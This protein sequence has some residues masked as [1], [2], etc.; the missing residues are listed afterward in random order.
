LAY[1]F[2]KCLPHCYSFSIFSHNITC[3]LRCSSDATVY[4][5]RAQGD[6]EDCSTFRSAEFI[7]EQVP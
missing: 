1:R 6:G 7:I 3:R 4:E 5:M 2:V